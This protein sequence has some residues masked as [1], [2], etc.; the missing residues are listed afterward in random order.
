M[1][2]TKLALQRPSEVVSQ[3][4]SRRLATDASGI[5]DIDV[6]IRKYSPENRSNWTGHF[7]SCLGQKWRKFSPELWEA[8]RELEDL[9]KKL[10]EEEQYV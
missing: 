4:R 2:E 7:T 1:T 5:W 9:A 8:R 10:G 3:I 6:G